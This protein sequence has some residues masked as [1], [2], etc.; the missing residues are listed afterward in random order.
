MSYMHHTVDS[1]TQGQH[2]FHVE[3]ISYVNNLHFPE[4]IKL[5]TQHVC[6]NAGV[7][8]FFLTKP[9]MVYIHIY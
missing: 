8:Y 3:G 1:I 7:V 5:L 4:T 9:I 2:I 6:D